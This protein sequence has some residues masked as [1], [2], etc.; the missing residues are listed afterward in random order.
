M[1]N[2]GSNLIS[3][4]FDLEIH[5]GKVAKLLA[6]SDNSAEEDKIIASQPQ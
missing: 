1:K 4:N 5:P 6:K 2:L 3:D